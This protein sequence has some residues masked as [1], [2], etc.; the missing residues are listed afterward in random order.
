MN[1]MVL[2]ILITQY[3]LL[4]LFK[5][6]RD[7]DSL[8]GKYSSYTEPFHACKDELPDGLNYHDKLTSLHEANTEV[9]ELIQDR[10]TEMKE[11]VDS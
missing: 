6:W 7:G 1:A 5:P 11:E 8:M 10:L 2:K 4:L 9:R 3:A